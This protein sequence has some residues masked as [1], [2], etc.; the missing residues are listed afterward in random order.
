[1]PSVLRPARRPTVTQ[2]S[3]PGPCGPPPPP[4]PAEAG[5]FCLFSVSLAVRPLTPG[6]YIL[7]LLWPINSAAV[8]GALTPAVF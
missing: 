2:L 3:D 7:V 6:A 1:M 8:H 4:R 5:G